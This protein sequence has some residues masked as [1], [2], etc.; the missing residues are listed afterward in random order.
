MVYILLFSNTHVCTSALEN[1][2]L[3]LEL[4]YNKPYDFNILLCINFENKLYY[5]ANSRTQYF[6]I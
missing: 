1:V 3:A 2:T 6:N 4:S 5:G